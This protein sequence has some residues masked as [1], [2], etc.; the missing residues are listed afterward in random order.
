MQVSI[1]NHQLCI[2]D[3]QIWNYARKSIS[4]WKNFY[5]NQ[6]NKCI[7][8]D[9]CGGFFITSH[10]HYSKHINPIINLEQIK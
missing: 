1:F 5:L 2:I 3:T 4:S 8:K 6:C 9:F 10:N 7:Q